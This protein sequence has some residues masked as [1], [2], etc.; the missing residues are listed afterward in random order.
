MVMYKTYVFL[1]I[2]FLFVSC[3][4]ETGIINE[5][6]IVNN[7]GYNVLFTAYNRQ[8]I[9]ITLKHGEKASETR[10][11]DTGEAEIFPMESDSIIIVFNDTHIVKYYNADVPRGRSPFNIDAYSKEPLGE[12]ND[13]IR[14]TYTYTITE[15][16]FGNATLLAETE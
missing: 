13:F 7:S 14:Y 8:D 1:A 2:M 6:V 3:T 15:E 4:K 11:G 12:K 9:A 5:T 10:V 16:D